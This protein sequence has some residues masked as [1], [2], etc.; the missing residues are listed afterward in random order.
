VRLFIAAFIALAATSARAQDQEPKLID[1]LLRPNMNLKNSAQ[2]KTFVAGGATV[3][4]Q[5]PAKSFGFRQ[6]VIEKT[7]AGQRELQPKT[8]PTRAFVA[9][10]TVA[11]VPSTG[12]ASNARSTY[13]TGPEWATGPAPESGKSVAVAQFATRPFLGRGKS[14]KA[15]SQKDTPLTVDQVRELLNKSK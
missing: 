8:V 13:R 9:S 5:V 4:K 3:D 1:R 15:L 11:N 10:K 12:W 14:Q 6:G 7:F 2:G